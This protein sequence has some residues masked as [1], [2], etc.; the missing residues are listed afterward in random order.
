ML[1]FNFDERFVIMDKSRF[2][3]DKGE[4]LANEYLIS[5]GYKILERNW[6]FN[7]KEIDIICTKNN[8]LVII[9]VKT[10]SSEYFGKPEEAVNFRKQ[11]FLIEATQNYIE[12]NDIDYEI[13]FDIISIILNDNET[14]IN[15]IK[16]AFKPTIF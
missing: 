3:G 2:F 15:H 11:K 14:K 12:Q 8:E 4:N 5:K 7:K 13:R 1:L 9:E 16:N 6:Y 10:R